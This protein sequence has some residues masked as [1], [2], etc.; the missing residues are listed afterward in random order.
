MSAKCKTLFLLRR[1]ATARHVTLLT[2]SLS[3]VTTQEKVLTG[4][5]TERW[6]N[7]Q[8]HQYHNWSSPTTPSLHIFTKTQSAF[9]VIQ[10]GLCTK[11]SQ[12]NQVNWRNRDMTCPRTKGGYYRVTAANDVSCRQGRLMRTNIPRCQSTRWSLK[13]RKMRCTSSKPKVSRGHAQPKTCCSSSLVRTASRRI[14]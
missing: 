12:N 6:T 13:L 9:K 11:V 4:L 3:R 7:I 14:W 8:Q 5:G 10:L 2:K 1:C